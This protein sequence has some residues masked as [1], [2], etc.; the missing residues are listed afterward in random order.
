MYPVIAVISLL[1][2]VCYYA[3]RRERQQSGFQ[4]VNPR[5]ILMAAKR[6]ENL[7]F[8]SSVVTA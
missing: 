2:S 3:H 6:P 4:F 7:L 1:V 5:V 8:R